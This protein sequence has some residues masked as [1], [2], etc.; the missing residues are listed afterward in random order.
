M[1]H[2]SKEG[3]FYVGKVAFESVALA[4]SLLTGQTVAF[5]PKH[6]QSSKSL[7]LR[8]DATL[9]HDRKNEGSRRENQV[10]RLSNENKSE[11]AHIRRGLAPGISNNRKIAAVLHLVNMELK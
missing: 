6:L 8:R 4:V 9:A 7:K 10:E 1:E 2:T 5:E 3:G 11:W